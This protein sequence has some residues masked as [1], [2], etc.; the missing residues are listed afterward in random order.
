MEIKIDGRMANVQELKRDGNIVTL[1]VDG[2][3]Y[4]VDA[5]MVEEGIYSILYKGRSYNLELI[6]DSSARNY[7][8]NSWYNTYQIE[9]ID[10]QTRYRMAREQGSHTDEG[11]V[12]VSPM[13][14]KVVKILVAEGDQ[15]EVGQTLIIISAMK[16]ESEFKAKVA[17]TIKH[18]SVKEG[19]TIDANKELISIG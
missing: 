1:K 6:A 9:I 2:D 7:T 10:A 19:D 4:E 18:V 14:G 5:L 17:G 8:V 15:V 16:M 3:I 13:P 11:N 12:I